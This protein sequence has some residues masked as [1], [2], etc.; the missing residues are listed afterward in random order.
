MRAKLNAENS[1]VV[2][3]DYTYRDLKKDAYP[4]TIPAEKNM[5]QAHWLEHNVVDVIEGDKPEYD[6]TT[7]MRV[8]DPVSKVGGQWVRNYSLVERSAEE[9]AQLQAAAEEAAAE[10]LKMS[11]VEILG[12][13]C[14]APGKD[15]A[16]LT[17]VAVGATRAQLAGGS[18]APTVF[19][20]ENGAELTITPDNFAEIEAIWTPFRQ[21]FFAP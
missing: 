16:G 6:E 11:G 2:K 8:A 12:V 7:H 9:V 13:M 17:A 19:K 3:E 20:F 14:S 21:S 1:S 15:Q 10:A 5:T 4:S 18:F